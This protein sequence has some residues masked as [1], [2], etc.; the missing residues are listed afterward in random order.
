MALQSAFM[1]ASLLGPERVA[2]VDAPDAAA[3]Q[4]RAM[5]TYEALWRD[6]FTTRLRVA[7]TFAHVAMRPVLSRA[8]WPLARRWPAALTLGAR[9]SG[10]TSCVPE[11]ARL[12]A[13][14]PAALA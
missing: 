6:R 8:L 7:A 11:A 13:S 2:L 3:R 4:W 12:A 5:A 1:L 14:R 9:W 10:K